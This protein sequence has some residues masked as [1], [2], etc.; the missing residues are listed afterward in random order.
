MVKKANGKVRL[1]VDFSIGLNDSLYIHQYPQPV[2]EDWF[3]KLYGRTWFVKVDLTDTSLQR[4]VDEN[5][6]N[7]LTINTHKG[8]FQINH[9]VFYCQVSVINFPT[10]DR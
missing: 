5:Y 10:N 6:K 9:I 7:L 3:T 8:L 4:D 1:C 2:P